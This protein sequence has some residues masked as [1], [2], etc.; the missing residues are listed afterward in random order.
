MDTT[1]VPASGG[2]E[3]THRGQRRIPGSGDHHEVGLGRR[4]V[5]RSR[6]PQPAVGPAVDELARHRFGPFGVARTDDHLLASGRQPHGETTAGRTGPTQ[7][8]NWHQHYPCTPIRGG[9]ER[10]R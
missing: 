9:S 5:L 10:Q 6:E 7:D 4:G 8:P 2:R 3:R 1:T